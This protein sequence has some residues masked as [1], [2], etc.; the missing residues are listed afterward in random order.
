MNKNFQ[1]LLL[2]IVAFAS[3]TTEQVA[4]AAQ[5]GLPAVTI[6]HIST[7]YA[8]QGMCSLR[9][10]LGTSMGD[11][12]A[13]E[14]S[15]KLKFVDTKGHELYRGEISA[16]LTDSEGG[17][18]QEVFLEDQNICFDSSTKIRVLRATAKPANKTFDLLKLHK[19]VVDDFKPMEISIPK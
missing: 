2:S 3:T 7:A 16:L 1:T 13:G 8:N 15:L 12:D 11:G 10:G 9:F 18:Y 19:V 4:V 14:V 6:R 5:D 17:R